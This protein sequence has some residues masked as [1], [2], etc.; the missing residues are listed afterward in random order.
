[1]S[2]PMKQLQDRI[3]QAIAVGLNRTAEIALTDIKAHVQVRTGKLRDSYA[4]L[5]RAT[6]DELAIVIDSSTVYRV[7][8][9]PFKIPPL[10]RSLNRAL[11]GNPLIDPAKHD[12][13]KLAVIAREQVEQSITE[14]LL[15]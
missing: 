7:Y 6:P 8:Y 4:I 15:S 5:K 2:D 13:S 1:M 11:Q 12:V 9:Y 14:E 10:P 3:A